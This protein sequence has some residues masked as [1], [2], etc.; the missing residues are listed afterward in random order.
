MNGYTHLPYVF[1]LHFLLQW[2]WTSLEPVLALVC[3]ILY[4]TANLRKLL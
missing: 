2:G 3:S 4:V 1:V